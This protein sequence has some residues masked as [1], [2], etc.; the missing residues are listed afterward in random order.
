MRVPARAPETSASSFVAFPEEKKRSC[1]RARLRWCRRG[2]ISYEA[3]T[4]RIAAKIFYAAKKS[5]RGR[6]GLKFFS[7]PNL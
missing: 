6:R 3:R 7:S 5:S 2:T 4:V 1:A